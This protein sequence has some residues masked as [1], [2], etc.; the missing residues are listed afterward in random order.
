[1]SEITTISSLPAK[2][3]L[4]SSDSLAVDDGV[5]TYKI[6][7]EQLRDFLKI[8]SAPIGTVSFSQSRKIEDNPGN[9]Q[10]IVT[11]RRIGYKWNV[12]E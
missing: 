2:T 10:K 12:T 7:G 1:M 3:A 6:S 5:H 8:N 9:P 4:L 11:V